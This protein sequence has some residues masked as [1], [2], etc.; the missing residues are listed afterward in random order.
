MKD[1]VLKNEKNTATYF[2]A[3]WGINIKAASIPKLPREIFD[4]NNG[5][6]IEVEIYFLLV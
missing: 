6:Y 1:I 4:N 2:E 5:D 3:F